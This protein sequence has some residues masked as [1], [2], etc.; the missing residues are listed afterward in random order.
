MEVVLFA[1]HPNIRQEEILHAYFAQLKAVLP[2]LLMEINVW[3]AQS[4]LEF[5]EMEVVLFAPHPN[6]RQE[7]ILHA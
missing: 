3:H 2:V 7:V 4:I 5:L 1:L 6:I